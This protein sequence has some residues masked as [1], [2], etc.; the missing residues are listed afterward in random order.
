MQAAFLLEYIF[1]S[2]PEEIC[3]RGDGDWDGGITEAPSHSLWGGE[4]GGGAVPRAENDEGV[5]YTDAQQQEGGGKVQR[6]ELDPN[7]TTK[8][9]AG[10]LKEKQR[11]RF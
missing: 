8:S 4:M 11:F 1:Q 2:L 3:E 7:V 10:N 6:D 5:V 9:K